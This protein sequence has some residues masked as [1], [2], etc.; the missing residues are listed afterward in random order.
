MASIDGINRFSASIILCQVS[1]QEFLNMEPE[2]R[3][4]RFGKF[5]GADAVVRGSTPDFLFLYLHT[6]VFSMI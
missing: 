2:E 1:L 4:T 5:I 3:I 6:C